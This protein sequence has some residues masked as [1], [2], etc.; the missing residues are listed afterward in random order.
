MKMKNQ[1]VELNKVKK[2]AMILRAVNHKLRQQIMNIIN[3]NGKIM[4][5][6]IYVKLRVEQ[7]V[8]SQHLA[9]LREAKVVDTQRN[10]K[11]VYYKINKETIS[12]INLFIDKLLK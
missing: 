10:G 11:C 12:D 8:C 1:L 2:A 7:S 9:I 4:V 6:D 3:D 5:T